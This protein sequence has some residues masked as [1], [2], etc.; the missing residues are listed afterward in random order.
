MMADLEI[1]DGEHGG[2]KSSESCPETRIVK[3]SHIKGKSIDL[4]RKNVV[5][6][7]SY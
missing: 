2:E 3:W 4:T 1:E 5:S 6:F 7:H